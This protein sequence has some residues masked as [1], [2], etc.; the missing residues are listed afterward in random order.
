MLYN[1]ILGNEP[2]RA[3]TIHQFTDQQKI[4]QQSTICQLFRFFFFINKLYEHFEDLQIFYF[5]I[6]MFCVL[7]E[8]NKKKLNM[9]TCFLGYCDGPCLLFS[10][11][12]IS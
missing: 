10:D 1:Y 9:T 12:L 11:M 2:S 4:Y 5:C 8:Q 7:V 3:E 6:F